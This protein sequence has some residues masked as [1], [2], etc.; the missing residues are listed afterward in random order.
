MYEM[1]KNPQY[2]QKVR[3]EVTAILS[4]H[5]GEITYE[6]LKEMSYIDSVIHEALRM[7]PPAFSMAKLCTKP[8]TMPMTSGQ[9]QPV[10][11]TP[12]TIVQIPLFGLHM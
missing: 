2:Q 5:N 7:H 1:A 11:I 6:S 3:D 4:K 10:T 9:T 12:G 8:Y